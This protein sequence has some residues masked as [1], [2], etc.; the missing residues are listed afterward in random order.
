MTDMAINLA[1]SSFIEMHIIVI[2][3]MLLRSEALVQSECSCS[4]MINDFLFQ[5]L[6]QVRYPFSSEFLMCKNI[7]LGMMIFF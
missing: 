1:F 6:N 3:F 2:L 5:C 4:F 7:D